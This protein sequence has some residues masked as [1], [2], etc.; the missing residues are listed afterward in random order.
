M[1]N[2][3]YISDD[4]STITETNSEII[5]QIYENEIDFLDSEKIDNNY[6][7]GSVLY[8]KKTE[9][10]ILSCSI[11]SK[12][13]FKYSK[14]EVIDYLYS[15]GTDDIY[16]YNVHMIKFLFNI[17]IMKLYIL[18]DKTYSIIVKT[19]WI[20]LIQRHFKKLYTEKMNIINERKK[21][22]NIQYNQLSG[23]YPFGLN[24]LPSIHGMLAVY[25]K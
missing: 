21:L 14:N 15:F 10:L 5:D 16:I 8:I 11:S 12:S 18:E 6:Y 13:F 19:H 7:I 1:N 24:V 20:H 3:E 4:E 22:K 25:S 17:Q 2:I 9:Q 23:K